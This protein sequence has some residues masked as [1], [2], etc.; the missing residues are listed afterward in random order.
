MDHLY[1]TNITA[2]S[3]RPDDSIEIL[4]F[5]NGSSVREIW[6]NEN[7]G[8]WILGAASK[9]R[10]LSANYERKGAIKGLVSK[11]V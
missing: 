11:A 3:P 5:S 1:I 6:A 9:A 10:A 4:R 2:G 7:L 8:T